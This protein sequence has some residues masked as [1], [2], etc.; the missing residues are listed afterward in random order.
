MVM[1]RKILE[2]YLAGFRGMQ[3]GRQLWA[4]IL[5]KLFLLFFVLKLFFLPNTLATHF[6]NDQ[7]RSDFVFQ[8]LTSACTTGQR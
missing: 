4:L 3:L 6:A 8:Q 2:F 7:Q 1:I 5:I